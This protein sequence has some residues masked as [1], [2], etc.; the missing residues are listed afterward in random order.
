MGYHHPMRFYVHCSDPAVIIPT[1]VYP[2][3]GIYESGN[4]TS[5]LV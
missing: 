4:K 2:G 3:L 1:P 5:K